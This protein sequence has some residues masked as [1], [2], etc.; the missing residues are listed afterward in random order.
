M[1]KSM[2]GHKRGLG[3]NKCF[4]TT[5]THDADVTFCQS[6][7]QMGSSDWKS[8]VADGWKTGASDNKQ[9]LW[10]VLIA[11]GFVAP[12]HVHEFCNFNFSDPAKLKT[13]FIFEVD[14]IRTQY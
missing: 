3:K 13:F 14:V 10:S 5:V 12:I 7:P 2:R 1:T 4:L 8:S 11:L 9:W 6:V